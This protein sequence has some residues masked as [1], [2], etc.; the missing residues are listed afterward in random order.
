M[1]TQR[2]KSAPYLPSYKPREAARPTTA[3][4]SRSCRRRDVVRAGSAGRA[5]RSSS[6]EDQLRSELRQMVRGAAYTGGV[7][8]RDPLKAIT[9]HY[10]ETPDERAKRLM[11]S[12]VAVSAVR[13]P[14][15]R[16]PAP[17]SQPRA[18]PSSVS[19]VEIERRRERCRRT[20]DGYH[21]SKGRERSLRP[22]SASCVDSWEDRMHKYVRQEAAWIR[23]R[24]SAA[25][26]AKSA[27]N[28]RSEKSHRVDSTVARENAREQLH[29]EDAIT[30]RDSTSTNE[31]DAWV[32][33]YFRMCS[34]SMDLRQHFFA[35][36]KLL[37]RE[38]TPIGPS[39]EGCKRALVHLGAY[40]QE[41]SMNLRARLMQRRAVGLCVRHQLGEKNA[42]VVLAVAKQ[43]GV[44][45]EA[46]VTQC[47]L[48]LV[49]EGFDKTLP[50][51]ADHAKARLIGIVSEASNKNGSA[52]QRAT[53]SVRRAPGAER[54]K[55]LAP[56]GAEARYGTLATNPAHHVARGF[57]SMA[58]GKILMFPD[59]TSRAVF[60]E[61]AYEEA[62][63]QIKKQ[64]ATPH[65]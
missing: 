61:A 40:L 17:E 2:P 11:D 45:N 31:Q 57:D 64:Q 18:R 44:T 15:R 56:T 16:S 38:E 59:G 41:N 12:R 65:R 14:L 60:T 35:A 20:V 50:L 10:S 43:H 24:T 3:N 53:D 46:E 33:D 27:K 34:N 48:G 1:A 26:R 54:R 5:S 30:H 23:S 7:Y 51:D 8:V 32:D 62:L 42:E 28:T 58:L 29:K 39:V 47:M 9:R 37:L 21:Q 4:P 19:A 63:K 13:E 25:T 49:D 52:G 36:E 55:P 22:Q 6:T